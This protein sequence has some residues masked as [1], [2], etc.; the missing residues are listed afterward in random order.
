ME[1][2]EFDVHEC[3]VKLLGSSFFRRMKVTMEKLVAIH[4]VITWCTLINATQFQ[5]TKHSLIW[6]RL[7]FCCCQWKSKVSIIHRS[8]P[9]ALSI[10]FVCIREP[11][12]SAMYVSAFAQHSYQMSSRMRGR[13]ICI[14]STIQMT[15]SSIII[16]ILNTDTY[17]NRKNTISLFTFIPTLKRHTFISYV[18]MFFLLRRKTA[19][20]HITFEMVTEKRMR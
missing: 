8:N 3:S 11:V 10:S 12:H 9:H 17:K 20:Q 7:F 16:S 19:H 5:S 4:V 14:I 2:V 1:F 6:W 15:H 13:I 18:N